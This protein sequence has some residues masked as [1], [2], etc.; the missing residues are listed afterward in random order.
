MLPQTVDTKTYK[1]FLAVE[2]KETRY[3]RTMFICLVF[4]NGRQKHLRTILPLRLNS[5]LA[6]E[7]KT[8]VD[9]ALKYAPEPDDETTVQLLSS[10]RSITIPEGT[11]ISAVYI[12]WRDNPAVVLL[13]HFILENPM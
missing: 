3:D 12:S 9:Y 10:L 5:T 11:G 2:T 4:D 1:I 13:K 7:I 6:E 8:A